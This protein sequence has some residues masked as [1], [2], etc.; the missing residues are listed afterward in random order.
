VF[1]CISIAIRKLRAPC[2]QILGAGPPRQGVQPDPRPAR[3]PGM[4][5]AAAKRTPAWLLPAAALVGVSCLLTLALGALTGGAEIGDDAPHLLELVRAPGILLRAPGESGLPETWQSFPPLLPA[6]FGL[7]VRPWLRV[8]SDFAAIRLGALTWTLLALL[9]TDGL[10]RAIGLQEGPRRNAAW[11]LALAPST[12][13]AVALLPQE[14]AYVALCAIG[15]FSVGATG[16]GIGL[17]LAA[18]AAVLAGKVLLAAVVV[19]VACFARRPL[20]ALAL[21]GGAMA[22]AQL[23]WLALQ[24]A[25]FGAVPLVGYSLDP[26]T[27]ISLWGMLSGLGVHLG[28]DATRALSGGATALGVLGASALARRH[29]L[30]LLEGVAVA[31]LV[32]LLTLAIA[33]PPYLLWDLPFLALAIGRM[34]GTPRRTGIA[35]VAGWGVTAYACK[36]LGGVALALEAPRPGGK[37]AVAKRVAGLL[38]EDFP[39]RA[40]RT[41]LLA[42]LAALGVGLAL[43]LWRQGRRL[44]GGLQTAE[45]APGGSKPVGRIGGIP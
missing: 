31:L 11:I 16:G 26:A 32:P 40:T 14:E 39:F 36:L 13:A 12:L 28:A 6:F 30:P 41:V 33:M 21:S 15:L 5:S 38:G 4:G 29:G 22:L 24:Q 18:A 17:A 44:N 3:S 43:L 42:L 37:P 1:V 25:R 9:A 8:T 10:G 23:G 34:D 35:L 27:S 2:G 7:G 19:P 45:G 20:R